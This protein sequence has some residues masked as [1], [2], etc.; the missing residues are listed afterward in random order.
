MSGVGD[1]LWVMS[2]AALVLSVDAQRLSPL[3]SLQ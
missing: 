1:D 2:L 3:G